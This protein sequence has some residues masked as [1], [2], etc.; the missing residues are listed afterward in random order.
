P[1]IEESPPRS[2]PR[3]RPETSFRH[4][5]TVLL[6][7]RETDCAK[8]KSPRPRENRSAAPD[9]PHQASSAPPPASPLRPIVSAPTPESPQYAVRIRACPFLST[10]AAPRVPG[11]DR[12][13]L[14]GLPHAVLRRPVGAFRGLRECH[15]YQKI[16]WASKK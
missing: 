11:A 2:L 15:L 7:C 5:K 14:R 1:R 4:A 10:R 12:R 6:H 13:R 9:T 16:V 3:S 8:R